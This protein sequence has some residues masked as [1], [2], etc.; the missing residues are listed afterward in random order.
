MGVRGLT[1]FV[2]SYQGVI[3]DLRE[4]AVA[5]PSSSTTTTLAVDAHAWIFDVWQTKFGDAVQG[6]D[7]QDIADHVEDVIDAWR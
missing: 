6:G 1:T 2:Q 3:S 4:F 5:S 7:Y